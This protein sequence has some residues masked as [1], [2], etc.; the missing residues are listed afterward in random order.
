[1]QA[2]L[3][4]I[5]WEVCNKVGGIYTVVRSK[6]GLMKASFKDRYFLIGP[7]FA[8]R[9]SVEFEELPPPETLKGIFEKLRNEGIICHYGKWLIRASPVVILVDSTSYANHKDQ[10]KTWFWERFGIDSLGTAFNDY[11]EPMVWGAAV[12][13]FIGEYEA[14]YGGQGII[15]HCHEWLAGGAA[16]ALKAGNSNVKVVFTTHATM[17]GRTIA[18]IDPGFYKKLDSIDPLKEAYRLGVHTKHLTERATAIHSDVFTTV[19]D[20]TG[21]EAERFFGRTP[22]LI[23]PNG[24]D[25]SAFPTFEEISIKHKLFKRRI[26]QFIKYA[27]FPHYPVDLDN[28]LIFFT[29][30]RYEFHGKGLDVYIDALRKLDKLL[31]KSPITVVNFFFVP[32]GSARGVHPDILENKTNLEDIKETIM[33]ELPEIEERLLSRLVEGRP[34]TKQ[35]II[36]PDVL[37]S[38]KKKLNR[39]RKPG[40]PRVCSHIMDNEDSDQMLMQFKA[41]N[42]VNSIENRVKVFLYP[43]YLTGADGVLDL[44]Y[45][46]CINGSQVGVFP[47][48]YEPWGYTPVEAAAL[49]DITI[50]TDLSGF[51]KYFL[52]NYPLEVNKGI[53]VIERFG[54]SDEEFSTKLAKLMHKLATMSKHERIDSK[55]HAKR[56][57]AEFDWSNL[58]R[59]YLKAYELALKNA[60]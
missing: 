16:L 5:S 17:L 44:N 25:L 54:L 53:Y 42:L 37:R 52:N 41:N 48:F 13:R 28:A 35:T 14:I 50:T 4:E 15:A 32:T 60:E 46:E 2:T 49:G 23:L 55:I 24:L 45:Y 59:F 27:L 47:S 29:A 36:S 6:A 38:I 20:I 7:Y 8:D 57:S 1:M 34:I 9:R 43:I 40:L 30:A 12:A 19:S 51:G 26:K 58:I 10:I 56:L 3:F 22:D 18:G 21:M 31:Q 11:D 39:F 33:E